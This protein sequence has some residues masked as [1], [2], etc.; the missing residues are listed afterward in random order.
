M[1]KHWA[2]RGAIALTCVTLV[3][4]CGG[5]D[6]ANDER[7]AQ[8]PEASSQAPAAAMVSLSGCV[9]TGTGTSQYVLRN[10]RFEPR[11]GDPQAATTTPGAHGITEGAW[12]RLE[13]DDQ[14]IEQYLGQRVKLTGSIAD[15][16]R[17][18]IGTAG[19]AGQQVPSGDRSQ[20]ASTADKE[21]KQA[22]EMGRIARESMADG[23]AAEV[24]VQQIQPTGDRCAA[25]TGR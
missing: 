14:N 19:T 12:V 18:T 15:D 2:A 24:Q 17:N 16:G 20:A 21:D 23:T 22:Q 25:P 7:R 11:H 3:A 10:V 5:D 1:R 4:A 6:G 9:E 13:G 8:G